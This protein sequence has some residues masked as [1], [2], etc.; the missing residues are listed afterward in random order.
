MADLALKVRPR[1]VLGKKVKTL[2]RGGVTP[3]NIYGHNV[4]S[5]AIEADTIELNLLLRRAG[6]TALVQ[7]S[8]E[9]EPAARP[10]LVRQ[11]TR[12]PT[13]DALLHVD[14]F[15]V[16]MREKLTVD[17]PLTLVGEAPA[18]EQ[19]DAIVV[20]SMDVI[21]VNCLPG[22]IPSHIDVDISTLIDTSSN[23]YVRDLRVP[24]DVEIMNDP[25]LPVASVS[26]KG[27]A[28]EEE[29]EAEEAAEVE[30]AAEEAVAEAVAEETAEEEASDSD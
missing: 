9:G 24:D 16:S 29:E 21:T 14:F 26:V 10:V 18:V 19:F 20:Q 4:P 5:L 11:L 27:I 13:N 6:R 15:Q 1:T 28:R 12:R 23:V 17:V 30:A 3:A 25:D 7:V 2:R 8:V 22:N